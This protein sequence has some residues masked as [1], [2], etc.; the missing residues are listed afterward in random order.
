MKT[1]LPILNPKAGALLLPKEFFN[2]TFT[3][4]WVGER[5]IKQFLWEQQ[6][7]DFRF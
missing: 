4:N 6:S 5:A 1:H 2:G 7:A 3:K